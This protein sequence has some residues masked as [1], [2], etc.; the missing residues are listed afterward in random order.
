MRDEK[1]VTWALIRCTRRKLSTKCS[2]KIQPRLC[3]I[4]ALYGSAHATGGCR[5]V[6]W[7]ISDSRLETTA[8]HKVAIRSAKV[9]CSFAKRKANTVPSIAEAAIAISIGQRILMKSKAR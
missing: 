2:Q 3:R 9:F 6:P 1:E 4:E 8:R 7:R 5:I